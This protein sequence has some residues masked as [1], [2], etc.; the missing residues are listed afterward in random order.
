MS[1]RPH[2]AFFEPPTFSGVD[3]S[4]SDRAHSQTVASVLSASEVLLEKPTGRM[5]SCSSL[6]LFILD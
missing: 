5:T 4:S 6:V 3:E 1:Y 2:V